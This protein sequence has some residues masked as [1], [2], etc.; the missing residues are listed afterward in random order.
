[1]YDPHK[2]LEEINRELNP[3]GYTAGF[4]AW[5]D[6]SRKMGSTSGDNISDSRLSGPEGQQYIAIRS[7]LGDE[8]IGKIALGKF[9]VVAQEDRDAHHSA[10]PLPL[11]EYLKDIRKYSGY[12]GLEEDSMYSQHVDGWATIRFQVTFLPS[13]KDGKATPFVPEM[14]NYQSRVGAP[15]NLVALV[16]P[17]GTSLQESAVGYAPLYAHARNPPHIGLQIL[18]ADATTTPVGEQV[19]ETEEERDELV[20]K[21]KATSTILGMEHMG[22]TC[23]IIAVIQIPLEDKP[24]TPPP[25][26]VRGLSLGHFSSP[27]A[28]DESLEGCAAY[29]SLPLACDEPLEECATYRSLG[30]LGI[31]DSAPLPKPASFVARVSQ[32][33][34]IKEVLTTCAKERKRHPTQRITITVHSYFV[35]E[36]GIPSAQDLQKAVQWLQE[37]YM[38]C[39]VNGQRFSM[40][41]TCT[42]AP[43]VKDDVYP[44]SK[45]MKIPVTV[46]EPWPPAPEAAPPQSFVC[47]LSQEVF[48]DP[49]TTSDGHTYEREL[50]AKWLSGS[51]TSP[52]TGLPLEST[53]LKP[54]FA[55]K[56]AIAEWKASL[57]QSKS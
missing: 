49:V 9:W 2:A 23:N 51:H 56:S 50:I 24:P 42:S 10:A 17:Q 41:E 45:K 30:N 28:C 22:K 20:R 18:E 55:V 7:P 31:P 47:P 32:G 40:P 48:Q 12:T 57:P 1:M 14:Y 5:D 11:D 29:R 38:M 3:T 27:L 43:V 52:L 15:Q 6:S 26:Q 37:S 16:T 21:G 8:R 53:R 19:V 44:P 46:I 39:D 54:N 4:I 34:T 25:L 35:C 33:Q 36:G 13:E